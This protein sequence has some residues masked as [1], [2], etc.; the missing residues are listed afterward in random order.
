[1]AEGIA[2]ARWPGRFEVLEDVPPLIIDGAHNPD[3]VKSLI[4]SIALYL[5]DWPVIFVMGV[6]AD[7]DYTQMLEMVSA[8]SNTLIAFKPGNP[9]GLSSDALA[10]RASHYFKQVT[11]AASQEEALKTARKLGAGKAAIVC[12]G[13]LSTMAGWYQLTGRKSSDGEY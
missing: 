7:K 12:F 11:A 3:G 4:D 10:E 5:R 13:S 6:F 8:Y 9:R 1:M 2:S